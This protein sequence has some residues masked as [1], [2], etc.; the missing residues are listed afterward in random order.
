MGC[1]VG[2]PRRFLNFDL[3]AE[4]SGTPRGTPEGQIWQKIFF[5]KC[6]FFC[7]FKLPLCLSRCRN[8]KITHKNFILGLNGVIEVTRSIFGNRTFFPNALL[9]Y[10][11]RLFS[12]NRGWTDRPTDGQTDGPTDTPSYRDARSILPF[13]YFR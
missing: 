9:F 2:L 4:I 10:F 13:R 8:A 3:E 1:R 11:T 12:I 6:D 5:Q 7:F